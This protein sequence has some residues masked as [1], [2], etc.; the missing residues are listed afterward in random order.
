[1]GT[2]SHNPLI[3]V[4]VHERQGHLTNGRHIAIQERS[5]L[6]SCHSWL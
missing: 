1:V 6:Q 2:G 4:F 3:S 5:G